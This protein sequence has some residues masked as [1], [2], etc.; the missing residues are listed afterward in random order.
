ME[1]D[2]IPEGAGKGEWIRR[3]GAG[4]E[5]WVRGEG[6]NG[7]TAAGRGEPERLMGGGEKRTTAVRQS[8][9]GGTRW[10]G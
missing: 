5:L 8:G 7:V 9:V 1:Y 2:Q 10:D 4:V 6:G 3:Q